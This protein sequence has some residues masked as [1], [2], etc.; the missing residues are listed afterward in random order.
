MMSLNCNKAASSV[1]KLLLPTLALLSESWYP[2]RAARAVCKVSGGS[3]KYLRG[4]WT[5]GFWTAGSIFMSSLY[6]LFPVQRAARSKWTS[7][8][9]SMGKAPGL[10]WCC[11]LGTAS[12]WGACQ[13]SKPHLIFRIAVQIQW[14]RP[15]AIQSCQ[16][17][18]ERTDLSVPVQREWRLITGH[19][20][21]CW[22]T[23]NTSNLVLWFFLQHFSL[24]MWIQHLQ[25]LGDGKS[26]WGEQSCGMFNG[27]FRGRSAWSG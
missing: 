9:P 14:A 26:E 15:A 16:H 12:A 6:N 5:H 25:H 7:F 10:C 2:G 8:L 11:S 4:R 24:F 19:A 23:R 20:E 18:S 22:L 17:C 27:T 13:L 1:E 3:Q 21:N